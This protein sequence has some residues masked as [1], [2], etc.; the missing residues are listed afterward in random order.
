MKNALK[1]SILMA[2]L[3]GIFLISREELPGIHALVEYQ[4]I[5]SMNK[6]IL[7]ATTIHHPGKG[8]SI[9]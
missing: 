3:T 1:V 2:A 4:K 8:T 7:F 5:T 9:E 6:K